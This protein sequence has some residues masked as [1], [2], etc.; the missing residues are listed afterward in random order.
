VELTVAGLDGT[1]PST[2]TVAIS[3]GPA[4]VLTVTAAQYRRGK[5]EWRIDG[6]SSIL[7]G[8][9]IKVHLGTSVVGTPVIGTA[10]VDGVGAWRIRITNSTAVPPAGVTSQPI[11]VESQRGGV[12]QGAQAFNATVG[13]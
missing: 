11:S 5:R 12:L 8:Q 7:A 2:D 6:T 13:N 1:T 4:D 9:T 10:A 3:P